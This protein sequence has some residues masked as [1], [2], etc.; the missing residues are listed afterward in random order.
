VRGEQI[1]GV[2]RFDKEIIHC[3]HVVPCLGILANAW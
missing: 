1:A 3:L 2:T